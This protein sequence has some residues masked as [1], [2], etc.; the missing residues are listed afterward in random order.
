[1]RACDRHEARSA[2]TES[3]AVEAILE[4]WDAGW[5]A[6]HPGSRL[7]FNLSQPLC[8][9]WTTRNE[10]AASD[11][12]G[13]LG[14]WARIAVRH[15]VSQQI[16]MGPIGSRRFQRSGNVFVQL[17][18]PVNTGQALLASL[19]DDVRSVMEGPQLG[20]DLVID[21]GSTREGDEDG[22]WCMSVVVLPF[23]YVET[24]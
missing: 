17:F 20:G 16:T 19:A 6:K 4:Q 13:P 9:P 22:Q 8:V 23:R 3:Q 21:A 5:E 15:A 24:R 7:P 2:V 18:G 10:A 1:M 14:A 12:L 11:Q